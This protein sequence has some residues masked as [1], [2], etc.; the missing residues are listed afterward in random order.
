[1]ISDTNNKIVVPAPV[2]VKPSTEWPTVVLFL[3]VMSVFSVSMFYALQAPNWALP[4]FIIL[5]TACVYSS[6]TV[7]HEASHRNISRRFPKLEYLI[8]TLT[9]FIFFHGSFDQFISIH[10]RHHSKVNQPGQD[11]DL[12]AQGPITLAR[13]LS[14]GATVMHYSNFY[15]KKGLHKP[16]R[17]VKMAIPYVLILTTYVAAFVSGFLPQLL[18]LW[19]LPS[20]FGVILTIYVFDHLPHRPHND[21]GKYTNSSI[22]PKPALDWL[23]FMQ[24]HHLIHHLWP[25][26]PWYRYRECFAQRRDDLLKAGAIVV[27]SSHQPRRIEVVV[28]KEFHQ[29][30]RQDKHEKEIPSQV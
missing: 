22:Y 14:W 4:F 26:I 30:S 7:I 28:A 21:T 8:G 17:F 12:H 11:P 25:S 5:N 16:E 2:W 27:G 24:S 10:L 29:E 6:F 15:W 3:V 20:L 9:G 23:L 13:L 19:T 1:M 18:L